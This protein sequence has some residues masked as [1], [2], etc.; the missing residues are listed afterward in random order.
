MSEDKKDETTGLFAEFKKILDKFQK[1]VPM[2]E[3]LTGNEDPSIFLFGK[4]G[5]KGEGYD[6]IG[7]FGNRVIG[8]SF[9]KDGKTSGFVSRI[10]SIIS[11][12]IEMDQKT[13]S[14]SLFD[15]NIGYNI[16]VDKGQQDN[17]KNLIDFIFNRR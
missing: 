12:S 10:D 14:L 4:I 8:F 15:G 7:V 17:A 5:E 2:L 11:V 3:I 13:I 6:S 9:E 16:D 1:V